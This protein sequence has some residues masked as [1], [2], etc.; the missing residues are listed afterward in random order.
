VASST[1]LSGPTNA[2]VGQDVTFTATV[3]TTGTTPT[4]TVSF[5]R[6]GVQFATGTLSGGRA[7]G[8][9]RFSAGTWTVTAHY[10][11]AG[12]VAASTSGA[13]TVRG[14]NAT[15]QTAPQA[16]FAG[17]GAVHGLSEA[18]AGQGWGA[19]AHPVQIR[20]RTAGEGR[21]SSQV[22]LTWATG[23]EHLEIAGPLLATGQALPAEARQIGTFYSQSPDR[24]RVQPL[25]LQVT[26]AA[27]AT[28]P[29]AAQEMVLRLLVQ[30]FAGIPG[31]IATVSGTLRRQP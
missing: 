24:P 14:V 28:D 31:C 21:A 3:R 12:A 9:G 22:T 23:A 4:G 2:A 17:G 19:P 25:T 11:G 20:Y 7:V 30:G 5:R 6:N 10:L 1:V 15:S 29:A 27:D 16:S 18:C 13:V 26:Q 8:V